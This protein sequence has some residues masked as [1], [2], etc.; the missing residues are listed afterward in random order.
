MG[1]KKSGPKKRDGERYA[2]G[3]LKPTGDPIQPAVWQ[4]IRAAA[5][6]DAGDP[7][8]ASEIGRLS[9][10]RELTNAQAAAAFRIGAIYGTF[11]RLKGSPRRAIASPSYERGFD[12]DSGVAE[13]LMAADVLADRN[14]RVDAAEKIWRGLQTEI[15]ILP[16][17]GRGVN[18]PRR[19]LELL[20]VDDRAVPGTDLDLVRAW[21]DDLAMVF[22]ISTS[23]RKPP[24]RRPAKRVITAGEAAGP[25]TQTPRAPDVDAL[26]IT[27]MLRK[28]RPDLSED[29]LRQAVQLAGALKDREIFNRKKQRSVRHGA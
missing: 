23:K 7:R 10:F 8:L 20:C 17:Y 11:E 2:C 22:G 27:M 13:E 4:R 19:L 5:T 29:D 14:Q 6:R 16:L 25:A 21:L 18:A 15:A 3:K 24:S 28:A 9:F 12:G 1:K 26:V